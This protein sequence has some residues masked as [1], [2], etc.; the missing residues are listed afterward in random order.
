MVSSAPRLGIDFGIQI[1]VRFRA[2]RLETHDI[3]QALERA[4][5]GIDPV[6]PIERFSHAGSP[7]E[8]TL[9]PQSL[10]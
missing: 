9:L 4:A 1:G 3:R 8:S 7:R 6:L 2:E 10:P 5:G